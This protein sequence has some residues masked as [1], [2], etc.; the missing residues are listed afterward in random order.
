MEAKLVQVDT[1][2]CIRRSFQIRRALNNKGFFQAGRRDA[3][4]M[5][6]RR[7]F[8]WSQHG[9]MMRCADSGGL[10]A[11]DPMSNCKYQKIQNASALQPAD[12]RGRGGVPGVGDGAVDDRLFLCGIREGLFRADASGVAGDGAQFGGQAEQ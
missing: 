5:R 11:A 7:V 4:R 3:G 10:A 2:S 8:G 6:K 1:I 12:Y 9:P